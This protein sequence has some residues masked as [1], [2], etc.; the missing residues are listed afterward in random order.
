MREELAIVQA[1]AGARDEIARSALE[2][3]DVLQLMCDTALGLLGADAMA[4]HLV[5]EDA[6][7]VCRVSG[8]P[9]RAIGVRLELGQSLAG[10]CIRTGHAVR[11]GDSL[12]DPRTDFGSVSR[13]GF[14]S[15]LC[16][17]ITDYGLPVGVLQ[18]GARREVAFGD[19]DETVLALLADVVAAHLL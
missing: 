17:P 18:A 2:L 4:A 6:L 3:D 15:L 13:S 8:Y 7:V 16:V 19:R 12:H 5:Q 9:E 10:Q 1:V 14:A 11:T